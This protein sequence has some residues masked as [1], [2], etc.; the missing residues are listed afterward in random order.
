MT[1]PA[2]A[3]STH[4]RLV[5]LIVHLSGWR[6]GESERL[7]SD[8]IPIGASVDAG[9]RLPAGSSAHAATLQRRGATYEL[10]VEPGND[11]WV[12]GERVDRIVLASGD[13]LEIGRG[14]PV[15]RFRLRPPGAG[16]DKSP[17]E[18]FADCWECARR[19]GG[20]VMSRTG[21]FAAQVPRELATKTSRGFRVAVILMLAVLV[22]AMSFLAGRTLSV[23]RRL[24]R[25]SIRVEGIAE[26]MT[27]AEEPIAT[28]GEVF[29]RMVDSLQAGLSSAAQRL[30]ALESQSGAAAR[31][32]EAA[33]R[34]TL[35][36]QGAYGF[37]DSTTGLPMRLVIGPDGQP[38]RGRDG[39][40]AVTTQG[41]GPEVEVMYTGT[42]FVVASEGLVLTNRHVATP[43]SY[44]GA[45]RRVAAQGWR[46]VMRRFVGYLPGVDAPFDVVTVEVSDSVD[47]AVLRCSGPVRTVPPLQLAERRARAG[48]EVLVLGYPLGIQA[49]LAR[50]EASVVRD[51]EGAGDLTFW[52]VAERLS[53][54]G[55]ITPL[56]S[57]GIVGQVT[58][59]TVVY[60]AETTHGGS[61]GPVLTLAGEVVAVNSAILPDFSG[62]NL[63]VPADR[64]SVLVRRVGSR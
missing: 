34:S 25:Q 46:P 51:L 23:E 6:R 64:A 28:S 48:D 57:R 3:S 61:G 41:T 8:S 20:S 12:N 16:D 49:M 29:E 63:G 31:V 2:H 30:E 54:A 27:R 18:V 5:P 47:L 19:E 13:V 40:P 35:F 21:T 60:D 10:I 26:L 11:V 39:I 37:Q 15:M 52:T 24:A 59:S 32:I 43:W 22:A 56:A 58:S 53:L 42:G 62:S 36:L 17:T 38:L 33:M 44:E 4:E 50:A 9:V 1:A 45:A 55:Q 14:G 7:A